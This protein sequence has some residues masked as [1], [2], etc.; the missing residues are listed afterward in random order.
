MTH[1]HFKEQLHL[2]VYEELDENEKGLLESHLATCNECR[3]ELIE[4]QK[5]RGLLAEHPTA[6]PN[7]GL[8]YE[9]RR[10]LQVA[11]RAQQNKPGLLTG[12]VEF[13]RSIGPQYKLA[14]G[15]MATL[16]IGF[17]VGYL[18]F[19]PSRTLVPP[20]QGEPLPQ[21]EYRISGLR[22]IDADA[23]D[24]E[25][26]I[27]F[28]AVKQMRLKGNIND[29]R[30]QRVLAHALINDQNPGVRLRTV[31]AFGAQALKFPDRELKAA[32][33]SALK[34]DP[35]PGVRQEALRVLRS[36][37]ID[38]EIKDAFLHVLMHD[39]NAGLRIAAINSLDSARAAT[40]GSDTE[41]LRVLQESMLSDQNNY[42]RLR[43]RSFLQEVKEQ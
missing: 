13:V 19:S 20:P 10:E 16:A 43:A 23:T 2:F 9:A 42:V 41:L 4:L 1:D 25:I 36:F 3:S 30:I 40:A 37:Q 24:G 33:V 27:A 35:N 32:L 21:Q 34:S 15:G 28:D 31:N 5:L 6:A 39:T 18:A 17:L 22:F 26:E 38:S 7:E 14:F 8:L 29:E 12:L 11:L